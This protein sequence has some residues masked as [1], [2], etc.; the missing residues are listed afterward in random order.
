MQRV[1]S[2]LVSFGSAGVVAKSYIKIYVRFALCS[3]VQINM[4][5][6]ELQNHVAQSRMENV[7][8]ECDPEGTDRV[9]RTELRD[10]LLAK[11]FA[12]NFVD[13]RCGSC[14]LLLLSA[15]SEV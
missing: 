7:F 14:V 10:A 1:Y 3:S 13:V 15:Y 5:P 12:E 4:A 2:E 11:G 6:P 8:D 9:K